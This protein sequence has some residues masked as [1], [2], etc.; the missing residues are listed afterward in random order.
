MKKYIALLACLIASSAF[1]QV[2]TYQV[3]GKVTGVDN[4]PVFQ[5]GGSYTLDFSFNDSDMFAPDFG[6]FKIFPALS[7]KFNYENGAYIGTMDSAYTWAV[8]YP[9]GVAF[10]IVS[11]FPGNTN[12]PTVQGNSL[13][14]TIPS[15]TNYS[16]QILSLYDQTGGSLSA[17][18]A[19]DLSNSSQFA[20]GLWEQFNLQWASVPNVPWSSLV[21]SVDS[22]ENIGPSLSPVPE[23]STYGF[24]GSAA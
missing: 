14:G 17:N 9:D 5:L 24:I 20:D 16:F 22:I 2:I 12:F 4:A 15:T 1:G 13:L 3:K 10:N 6:S 23:P 7:L 21:G 11:P 19:I 18:A 8:N